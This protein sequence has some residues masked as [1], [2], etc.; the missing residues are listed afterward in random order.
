MNLKDHSAF[1]LGTNI[2]VGTMN[3]INIKLCVMVEL[4]EFSDLD[5]ISFSVTVASNS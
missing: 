2:S 4:T 1:G 3:V 5:L